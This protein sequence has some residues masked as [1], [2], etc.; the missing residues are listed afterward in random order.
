MTRRAR[1]T[2]AGGRRRRTANQSSAPTVIATAAT[3]LLWTA[4]SAPVV[5]P[6]P[7]AQSMR[8]RR[9]RAA[10]R[11][12]KAISQTQTSGKSAFSDIA[13]WERTVIAG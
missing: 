7:A 3:I 12:A 8:G 4:H 13:T 1:T 6:R 11:P 10:S 9:S 5:A 2:G